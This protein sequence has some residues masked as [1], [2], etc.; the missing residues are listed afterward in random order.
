MT[1]EM[2]SI[3][4]VDVNFGHFKSEM[5]VLLS[6]Q[7]TPLKEEIASLTQLLKQRD[8]KI[9]ALEVKI[10]RQDARIEALEMK[11]NSQDERIRSLENQ[12][13]Q[14]TASNIAL[15]S[16]MSVLRVGI[17]D[18]EQRG[19]KM[20]L[21]IEGLEYKRN[22]TDQELR[23]DIV[24]K[25]NEFEANI[26]DEDICRAHRTARP[27]KDRDSPTIV[28]QTIVRFRSWGARTRAYRAKFY[29]KANQKREQ[30]NCDL[31]KRRLDLLNRA[32]SILGKHPVAHVYADAECR[33]LL[34]IRPTDEKIPFNNEAELQSAIA[35]I[36]MQPVLAAPV[37]VG[38]FPPLQGTQPLSAIVEESAK[39]DV[40]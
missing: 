25:L 14:S 18:Q 27:K 6:A 32:R 34:K 13:L 17:D 21:R 39:E 10:I 16:E 33:L 2:T 4:T 19:R 15:R 38:I 26:T 36:P 7:I 23:A 35:K 3:E 8:A 5:E 22:E 28:A 20:S 31:T 37:S 12:L 30:I 1:T 9:E 29:S 11:A 24:A 40:E